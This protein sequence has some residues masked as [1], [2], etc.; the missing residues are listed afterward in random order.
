MSDSVIHGQKTSTPEA[1]VQSIVPDDSV[2]PT[3]AQRTK[4]ASIEARPTQRRQLEA[5]TH[6]GNEVARIAIKD[7]A[8]VIFVDAIDVIVAKAEGNYVAL[9]HKAGCYLVRETMA[10]IEEKLSPL[11]FVRIHRSIVVNAN[12]VKDLRRDGT[13]TY[14]LR[15]TDGTQHPVGRAYKHNLK[16][17]ACSWL[18]TDVL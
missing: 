10:T 9:I 11:G 12:L 8:R 2:V 5:K 6:G 1:L 15:T 3:S 17:I 4:I 14:L 16:V 18:G 13:G 7:K